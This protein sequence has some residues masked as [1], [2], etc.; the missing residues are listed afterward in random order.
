M[1]ARSR[2]PIRHPGEGNRHYALR[3]ARQPLRRMG[4]DIQRV[5]PNRRETLE[6][7]FQQLAHTG[8]D[9]RTV[10]DV[11]VAHGTPELYDAFPSAR[12]LLVE[13]LAEH[14]PALRKILERVDGEYAMAAAAS[15]SG[16]IEFSVSPDPADHWNSS[17]YRS[18]DAD[19]HGWQERSVPS[20]RL[21]D[22][23]A[24]RGLEAPFLIKVDAEGAELEALSGADDVLTKT[25]AVVLEV[26]LIDYFE[27]AP[28]FAEVVGFMADRGFQVYDIVGGFNR[29][30]DGALVLVDVVF[31]REG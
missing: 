18:A 3:L 9:P 19:A 31:R 7:A 25:E 21:D 12:F 14:E 16:T 8:M 2:L 17:I 5:A 24:E 30:S 20:V 26:T 1:R 4:Y 13:A 23:V 27:G 29:E 6:Q 22:L 11:G 10:I 28:R 15:T